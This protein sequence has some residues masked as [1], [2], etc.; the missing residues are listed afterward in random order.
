MLHNY[1]NYAYETWWQIFFILIT[2]HDWW[3]MQMNYHEAVV[4]NH[5]IHAINLHSVNKKI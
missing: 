1:Y 5:V 4:K 3:S 2:L